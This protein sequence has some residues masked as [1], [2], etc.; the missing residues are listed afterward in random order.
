MRLFVAILPPAAAL[1]ELA[2]VAG[3]LQF[4]APGLRWAARPSWH[5]TLA[6]LGEVS[7]QKLTGLASRLERAAGRYPPQQLAIA[8]AGAFPGAGRARVLWA[9]VAGDRQALS[10]LAGSVAAGARRAGAPSAD[11]NRPYHPHLTLARSREPADVT[12][13]IAALSG[14]AGSPWP[15]DSIHLMRSRLSA[16]RPQ[17]EIAGSWPLAKTGGKGTPARRQ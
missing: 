10:R 11:E 7:E 5:L 3:P 13:L 12:G 6:F 4:A 1:E 2:A 15:A 8:G 17:Y 9:G 14:F 16:G